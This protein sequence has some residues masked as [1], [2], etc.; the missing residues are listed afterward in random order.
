M[1]VRQ[2]ARRLGLATEALAHLRITRE[3]A[4]QHLDHHATTEGDVPRLV[5]V[6]HAAGRETPDDRVPATGRTTQRADLAVGDVRRRCRHV[7][8]RDATAHAAWLSGAG[9]DRRAVRR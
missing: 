1:R 5:D 8:E 7:G 2:P 3:V 6:R 9:S 4:V